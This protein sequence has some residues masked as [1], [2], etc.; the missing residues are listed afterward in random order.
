MLTKSKSALAEAG[1]VNPLFKEIEIVPP[2]ITFSSGEIYLRVGKKQICIFPTPG[3]SEDGISVLIED[4]RIL[5]TG[6]AFMPI[7]FV[8]GG[9]FDVLLDTLKTIGSMSLE[10]IIQGHGDIILRGEIEEAVKIN[11]NYLHF[12]HK[13]AKTAMRRR[14]P[15]EFL[16]AQNV[17]AGGKSRVLLG[18]LAQDLHQRNLFSLYR[19]MIK[20]AK[21]LEQ[22]S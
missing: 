6:D 7:P 18:G 21:A 1:E 22:E 9:D 5:F 8:V 13:L 20:Q 4:D 17:E 3:H 15:I 10:N 19:E 11:T 12:I 14:S 2:Q 16:Q